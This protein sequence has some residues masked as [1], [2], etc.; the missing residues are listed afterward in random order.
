MKVWEKPGLKTQKLNDDSFWLFYFVTYFMQEA[1]LDWLTDNWEGKEGLRETWVENTQIN[2]D[3]SFR[4]FYFVTY[5]MEEAFLDWWTDNWELGKGW[6]K[7]VRCTPGMWQWITPQD[8]P[9]GGG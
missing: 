7:P 4:L 1:F 3:D 2:N 5:F 8:C 6:G 9:W